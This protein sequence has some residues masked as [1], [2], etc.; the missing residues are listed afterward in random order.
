MATKLRA[1]SST[2]LSE[3]YEKRT[4]KYF[5]RSKKILKEEGINPIVRYQVFA[6]RDVESLAGIDEAVDFIR[7][8][9]DN[10]GRE[11]IRVYSLRN[12]QEYSSGEPMMKIEG[13]VQDLIDLETV[14]LGI[15]SGGLTGRVDLEEL[16]KRAPEVV[17]AANG[18]PVIYFGARHFSPELDY[19]ITKICKEAGFTSTSTDVGARAWGPDARGVGTIPHALSLS[20]AA[21]IKINKIEGSPVV[22]AVIGFDK[23]IDE[24][25]PR[26]NLTD[27]YNHEIDDTMASA[28][29]LGN[30]LRGVRVDTCGEN[31]AQGKETVDEGEVSEEIRESK[32][33]DG[34]GVK[35][36]GV[37]AL[38]KAMIESGREDLELIVSSG[39]NAEKTADFVR[40]DEEFQGRYGTELFHGIGTGSFSMPIVM[41]T[42]DIVSFYDEEKGLWIPNS[43][44]GRGE[45]PSDRLELVLGGEK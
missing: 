8:V 26:I 7:K 17:R 31:Y 29:A 42:S 39:F 41:T 19:E 18:K 23:H 34:R 21:H 12:G 24:K 10:E 35:I 3:D 14:Y 4:D 1:Y 13:R 38:R 40:A 27:T 33:W 5:L 22:A 9:R 11:G 20:Y 30:K 43:K 32:H 6:R 28:M 36:R 25:V 2:K 37:W 45:K 15:I 16:N 44:T